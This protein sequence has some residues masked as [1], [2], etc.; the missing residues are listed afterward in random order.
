M[1]G[2]GGTVDDEVIERD[3]RY[4]YK[5][6]D[7]EMDE[8][9]ATAVDEP[10][11]ANR[12]GK[13]VE[14]VISSRLAAVVMSGLVIFGALVAGILL[15]LYFQDK[16]TMEQAV[17]PVLA[18]QP[19]VPVVESSRDLPASVWNEPGLIRVGEPAP[20]FSLKDLDG[21]LIRLSDFRGKAVLVN[22]WATWC[23]PCRFEMPTLQRVYEKHRPHDFVVL[24]VDTGERSSGESMR[25]AAKGFASS[26]NLTFPIVLD[27][28]D[29]V[30]NLYNLRAY[31]TS[32]F[33]DREGKLTDVRR[34]A[35]VNE[36]DIE[37]YLAKL[38]PEGSIQ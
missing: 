12:T 5:F 26:L 11:P 21:K 13:E 36:K 6:L 28:G 19:Q 23:P 4:G 30:A 25:I 10:I 37:R 35:F 1:Q 34:G 33:V 9:P 22:F 17:V 2:V 31:P 32:F 16:R 24:A 27:E 3:D 38:L 29:Q 18:P 14:I 15:G 20:D 7:T 8:F